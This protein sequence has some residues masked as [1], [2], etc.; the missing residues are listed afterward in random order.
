VDLSEHV[1]RLV[2]HPLAVL[3]STPF[4]TLLMTPA[5]DEWI[6]IVAISFEINEAQC[7]AVVISCDVP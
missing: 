6:F 3:A 4:L 2:F 1:L 7:Q 5:Q